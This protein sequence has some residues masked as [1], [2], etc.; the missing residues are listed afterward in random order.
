MTH[1]HVLRICMA[2]MAFDGFM[3]AR[4]SAANDER[5]LN[6]VR[7]HFEWLATFSFI[8]IPPEFV[9]T[10][11]RSFCARARSLV[12]HSQPILAVIRMSVISEYIYL[13][14]LLLLFNLR[15]FSNICPVA[16]FAYE[17]FGP[18]ICRSQSA[19]RADQMPSSG[20]AKA[21]KRTENDPD[22]VDKCSV[23]SA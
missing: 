3:R 5:L 1:N 7:A 11:F 2:N 18:Q 6:V 20:R 13:Y 15:Q 19:M 16:T 8:E 14:L 23:A 17:N 22:D 12:D 4:E 10:Q 21:G 9:L